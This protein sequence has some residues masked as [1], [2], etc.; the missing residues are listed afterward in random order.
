VRVCRYSPD[1]ECLGC[2]RL[3]S[4][5]VAW[6]RLSADQRDAIASFAVERRERRWRMRAERKAAA[7][8]NTK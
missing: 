1:D 4:E 2:F 5:V 3:R 6:S 8:S 7:A